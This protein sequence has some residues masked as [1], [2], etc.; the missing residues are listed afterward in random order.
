M[1][2][3]G[4]GLV[5]LVRRVAGVGLAAVLIVVVAAV[6]RVPW[7]A[8]SEQG[9]LRLSWRVAVDAQEVCRAPTDDEVAGLPAHMRPQTVCV[10]DSSA[11]TLRVRVDGATVLERGYAGAGARADRPVYVFE[12][13]PLAPGSHRVGVEFLPAEGGPGRALALDAPVIVRAG[14]ALLVTRPSRD[15][16]LTL[17]PGGVPGDR[18]VR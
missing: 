1:G 17:L 6:S 13:I 2:P 12:E 18:A 3:G 9:L 7:A 5:S 15:E 14:Y 8:R 16:G 11:Y 10:S 4:E